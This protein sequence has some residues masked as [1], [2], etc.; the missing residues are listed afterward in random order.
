MIKT[1]RGALKADVSVNEIARLLD[2]PLSPPLTESESNG[3]LSNAMVES[4]AESNPENDNGKSGKSLGV[5]AEACLLYLT[6]IGEAHPVAYDLIYALPNL[7]VYGLVEEGF[8]D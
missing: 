5:S 3:L 4:F 1:M 6:G 8:M 7:Q 2:L